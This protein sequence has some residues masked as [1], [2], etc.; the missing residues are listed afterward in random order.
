MEA[1]SLISQLICGNEKKGMVEMEESY[2]VVVELKVKRIQ[3]E[4]MSLAAI[5]P[6][7]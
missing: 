1:I 4:D 7:K 2:R 6:I 3:S 5:I